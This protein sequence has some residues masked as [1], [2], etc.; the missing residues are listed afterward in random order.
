MSEASTTFQVERTERSRLADVEFEKLSFGTVFSDHMLVAEYQDGR[1]LPPSIKPYGPLSLDPSISALQYGISVF[2]GLKAHRSP[3][4]EILL[5]RAAENARRLRRSAARLAMPAVPDSLFL[6]GL[7][8]LLHTDRGWVPPADRGAL[9]IR[10]VLFSI[11]PSLRVT[12]AARYLFVIFTS[13]FGAYF[14]APVEVLVTE[15]YVRAFPGGTGDIKPAG[16]YAAGLL[17]DREAREAGYNS[18]MWL[19]GMERRFIEECG[20]MNVFFVLEDRVVTPESTGTFL[21]GVTRDSVMTLLRGMGLRV[22]EER[23]SIDDLIRSFDRGYLRECFGTGTAATISPIR[24]IRYR[25]RELELTPAPE[26]TLAARLREQ[27]LAIMT[28]RAPDPYG[29][30]EPVRLDS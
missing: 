9:Y 10:P 30:V 21:P 16:N 19:D 20:V 2:E 7:R 22:E 5:F 14:S 23:F 15:H 29:W 28:G 12:P 11:D 13:P 17:A 18:V 25:E 26:R 3:R 4:G 27:L 1:W 24:R 8:E 6:D